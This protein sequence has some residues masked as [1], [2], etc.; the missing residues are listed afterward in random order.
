MEYF[1]I[2]NGSLKPSSV[3]QMRKIAE[4]LSVESGH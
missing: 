1:L 2:D 3:L 4:L